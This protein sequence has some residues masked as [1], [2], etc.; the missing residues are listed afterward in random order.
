MGFTN[1]KVTDCFAS[2][3]LLYSDGL[4][5]PELSVHFTNYNSNLWL[6]TLYNDY[7]FVLDDE[8]VY[9]CYLRRTAEGKVKSRIRI[10]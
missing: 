4:T 10:L 6:G 1:V 5:S 7:C 8:G 2:G 9:Y 3:V